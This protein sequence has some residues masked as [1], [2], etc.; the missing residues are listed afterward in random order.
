[1]SL[2][3]RVAPLLHTGWF[4]AERSAIA[5]LKRNF[6]HDSLRDAFAKAHCPLHQ[7]PSI[8]M[9]HPRRWKVAD[10]DRG[11]L[12]KDVGN[13]LVI[14]REVSPAI[15]R[16]IEFLAF[17]SKERFYTSKWRFE[18]MS[19]QCRWT[20]EK[21]LEDR[22]DVLMVNIG[23]GSW[24]VPKWKVMEYRG[25]WYN[26]Y[27]PGFIDFNHDLT[28][29]A[30]FPF[31]DRSVHLFYC[32]HV[33]E[34]L[35]NRCCAHLFREAFRSLELGG[36][37]RIVMPDADLI[38]DRLRKR[39]TGFFKSWMDRDNS[40]LEE[41]FCTLV[42]QSRYLEKAEID[43]RLATMDE[44]E[45]LDWC[46]EGLE[47]DR[48]KAGEHINWFNFEKLSRMLSEA[49]F[50]GIRRSSPQE[51]LFCE[52][53]GPGFDTRPWYSLHVDCVRAS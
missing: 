19:M 52:A 38:Y 35:S 28:S 43:R 47:Y 14:T 33:I 16:L 24:H 26:Y 45:F 8:E 23:A 37:F 21:Y 49:G 22:S 27:L 1:M 7:N 40:S 13:Q 53:R 6:V 18:Q 15:C 34:H 5:G 48:A 30:P 32:E 17:R 50:T 42:A 46:D 36:G 41:A 11:Y 2:R 31:A 51:S 9:I 20:A 4:S 44:D 39:D 10:G 25:P 12:I 3:N 29:D